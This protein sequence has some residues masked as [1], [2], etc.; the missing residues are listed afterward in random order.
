MTFL[1]N[2]HFPFFCNQLY[3]ESLNDLFEHR[4]FD[5]TVVDDDFLTL[6]VPVIMN[7]CNCD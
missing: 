6:P 2:F 3:G 4:C 5:I 1:E 7:W